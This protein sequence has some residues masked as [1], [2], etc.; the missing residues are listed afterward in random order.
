MPSNATIAAIR[1]GC[2]LSPLAPAP[3]DAAAILAGLAAPDQALAD[4]P[5]PDPQ[6]VWALGHQ[7]T[8]H[9]RDARANVPGAAEALKETRRQINVM[10]DAALLNFVQRGVYG[11]SGFRER[12]QDFWTN[13][14]TVVGKL[15]R[16]KA[17]PS[18]FADEAVRPHMTGRFTDLLTAVVT[19][20]AM[21]IY[22]DQITSSGPQSRAGERQK[23][24]LNENLAR[25]VLEL[26]TLGVGAGY[27]QT[28]VRQFA[29]LLT[30]LTLDNKDGQFRFNPN[31]VEP[32]AETLLGKTYG[33]PPKDKLAQIHRALDDIALRPETAQ[34]IA[35]KIA[36]HFVADTPDP[37]LV[38]AMTAAYRRSG[39]DLTAVYSAML[40]HPAAWAPP[41]AKVRMPFDY[42]VAALRALA[43]PRETLAGLRPQ[44]IQRFVQTPLIGMGQPFQQAPGPNGWHEDSAGWVTPS[45]LAA[46]IQWAMAVPQQL[47]PDLPD[48]RDFVQ[49][50]LADAASQT[51]IDAARQAEN[52]REG[53]GLVLA[54][55]DFN[56]R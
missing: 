50:A 30:G 8:E 45:L 9:N 33:G 4:F 2:G 44:Q 11:A 26:H 32:A 41:G 5:G 56:R 15:A 10:N 36:V 47:L 6:Q 23:R 48:P 13:H 22:L 53:V 25:E 37:G 28:D 46:R 34:H 3:A 24:G 1:F 14:F 39:G 7:V 20:P 19:H 31:M 43:P 12:L 29:Y 40:D 54:S 17:I 16:V 42:I 21:L 18:V 27:S 38:Q 55:N 35:T 52:R 49:V 51:V